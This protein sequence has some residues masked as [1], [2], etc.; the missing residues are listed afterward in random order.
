MDIQKFKKIGKSKY[1]VYLNNSEVILYEDVILKYNLLLQ[2]NIDLKKMDKILKENKYYEVYYSA[3]SYVEIK[4]RSESEVRQYLTNKGY[5]ITEINEVIE[6]LKEQN[7][8]NN[9]SYIK[10]Y[11]NDKIYLSHDGPEKIKNQL[12]T[13]GLD[14]SLITSYIEKI[15]ESIWIEKIDKI[16]EKRKK[17]NKLSK[18]A[19]INKTHIHLLTLGYRVDLIHE[20]LHNINI[21]NKQEIVKDYKKAYDKYNNKYTD[22]ELKYRIQNYLY[23]KQYSTEEINEIIDLNQ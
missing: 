4:M 7:I 22:K 15:E 23:R 14:E 20:R 19:F 12:I 21:D 6:K 13:L 8:I 11:I 9:E 5:D 10:S 1:K 3:L 2:K 17:I 16:V 18:N